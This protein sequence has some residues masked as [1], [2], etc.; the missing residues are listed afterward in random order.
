MLLVNVPS[1]ALDSS[2]VSVA[3]FTCLVAHEVIPSQPDCR[4]SDLARPK[5]KP[6]PHGDLVPVS[7]PLD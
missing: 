4:G 5:R 7:P 2:S 1:T 3:P 6:H